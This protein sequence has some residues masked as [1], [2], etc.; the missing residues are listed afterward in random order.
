MT[1]ITL[2]QLAE[3]IGGEMVGDP[4]LELVGVAP[5]H[6][7][8]ADQVS[9][10]SN[11]RYAASLETTSAGAVIVSRDQD[12]PGLNLIRIDDP[13]LGFALAMDVFHFEP[14]DPAGVSP[15]ASVHPGGKVGSDPSIHPF[16]VVCDG[17]RI[18]SRVTLMPGSY[19]GPDAVVDDDTVLHPNVVIEKNVLVGKR[20]IIHAGTVVGSDGFGFAREKGGHRKIIQ[21]GTVRVEDDVEIGAGC[22][23]DRAV[24]G[25]TVVGAGSKLDNL[26]QVGHNVRIGK[27]CILVAQAAIAGSTTLEDNVTMAGQS[28]VAGHL[29]I[30]EGS[31]IYGR[32]AVIKDVPAGSQ[33]AGLIPAVDVREWRRTAAALGSLGSLRKRVAAL[34]KEIKKLHGGSREED[35]N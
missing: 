5:L 26:I 24:M 14:Y 12:A 11:P 27:N 4:H 29:T 25:E 17:A 3:R 8:A 33:V 21:A 20:V 6:I 7:A 16:A 22:T 13:Y 19:V 15:L 10:L 35:D 18:G 2:E 9:F 31:L 34:E 1:K 30:G 28:G 23:I 32:A